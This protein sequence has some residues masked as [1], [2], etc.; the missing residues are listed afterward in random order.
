MDYSYQRNYFQTAYATGSD[1]WTSANISLDVEHFVERLPAGAMI[2]DLGSGR[3]RLPFRLAELGF[4]VIGLD[5]IKDIVSKN[6]EEVKL[7]KLEGKLRFIEGDV[8]DIP[9]A[10]ASF[11]AVIDVGLLHHL[12][13]EDWSDYRKEV[14]RVLRP[15]GKFFLVA[16]SKDTLK[17]LTWHP[18]TES[19]STFERDGTI[20][21]FFTDEELEL[22]FETDCDIESASTETIPTHGDKVVTHVMVFK[23]K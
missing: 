16:H 20:Y 1:V 11:D 19:V 3:G 8:F 7:K 14:L 5:Y 17:F 6:N 4:K 12:H 22:L 13:P 10:D 18:K 23:K 21:H 2:L 9:L 15:G